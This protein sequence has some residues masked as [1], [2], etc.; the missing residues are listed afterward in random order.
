MIQKTPSTLVDHGTP[1]HLLGEHYEILLG[2]LFAQRNGQADKPFAIG[3]TAGSSGEGVSSVAANLAMTA[4][5]ANLGQVLLVEANEKAP[6]L[7]RKFR[8]AN[9]PGLTEA[10]SQRAELDDCLQ[11]THIENL[12]VLPVGNGEQQETRDVANLIDD[13]KRDFN[14]IIF[15]L[16]PARQSD[17]NSAVLAAT[18]D[19]VLLVVE[20]RRAGSQSAQRTKRHLIDRRANVLGVV[21]NKTN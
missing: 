20:A 4:A 16:P 17:A 7:N 18:L 1:R 15:D 21:L 6:S 9:G 5:G 3:I 14:L 2:R 12:Y 11:C 19:G 13:L 8:L 10:L